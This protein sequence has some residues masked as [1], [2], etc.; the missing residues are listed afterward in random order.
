M[1]YHQSSSR[2]FGAYC[3]I[4][5]KNLTV[6]SKLLSHCLTSA[7]TCSSVLIIIHVF[8]C[9]CA[10]CLCIKDIITVL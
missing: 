10:F 2:R 4:F 1:Y 3:A 9:I 7:G 5:K 8:Y 6:C